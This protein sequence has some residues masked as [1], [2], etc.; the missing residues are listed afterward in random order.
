MLTPKR[1][2]YRKWHKGRSKGLDRKANE[3]AFGSYGLKSLGTK[4]ISARQLESGRRTI[5]RYLKKGGRVWLRVFPDKPVTT[6]GPESPLGGGK[7]AV[8]HY[9]FPIR[10]GRIIFE[11]EGI[12]EAQAK[13]ALKEA[14]S[15]IPIH[16]KIIAKNA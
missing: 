1:V 9:V 12:P 3:L 2:K 16:T 10:P 14:A 13:E 4:W 6:K 7:G 15:K 5:I 8:D 11:V